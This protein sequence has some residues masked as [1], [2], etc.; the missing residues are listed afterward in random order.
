MN[1]E[2]AKKLK[3][4]GFPFQEI[5]ANEYTDDRNYR[6]DVAEMAAVG[7]VGSQ[8]APFV[9]FEGEETIY[10]I[11]TL[12]ELIEACGDRFWKIEKHGSVFYA[13]RTQRK[14]HVD[15][16]S[17]LFEFVKGVDTRAQGTTPEE[18]VANLWLALNE[19]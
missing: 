6:S 13:Y 10:S 9:V 2:L 16:A 19:K 1:Y 12:S 3:D 18:A 5:H 4:G 17:S 14:I 8:A 15:S 11:P 7:F